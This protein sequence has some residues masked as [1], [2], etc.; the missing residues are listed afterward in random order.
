[1]RVRATLETSD[2]GLVIDHE[3]LD[4]LDLVRWQLNQRRGRGI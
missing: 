4:M 3:K 1:M 2:S